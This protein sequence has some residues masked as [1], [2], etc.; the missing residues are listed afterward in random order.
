MAK[1]EFTASFI[2]TAFIPLL[3]N[4]NMQE[5]PIPNNFKGPFPDFNSNFFRYFGALLITTMLINMVYPIVEFCMFYVIRLITRLRDSSCTLNRYR[6]KSTSV[7]Q[8]I[9]RRGG[10]VFF[11]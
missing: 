5:Q 1:L 11:I 6:T 7:H 2:N 9:E 10:P 8:Y 4:A 3:I